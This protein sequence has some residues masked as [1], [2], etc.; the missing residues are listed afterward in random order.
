LRAIQRQ[1]QLRLHL[2]FFLYFQLK[3]N[4][5]EVKRKILH[6]FFKKVEKFFSFIVLQVI[7]L[8]LEIPS[9]NG[10]LMG[11]HRLG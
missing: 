4:S 6:L 11:L 7:V 9:S 3:K 2:T 1:D 5:F 8:Q 10:I